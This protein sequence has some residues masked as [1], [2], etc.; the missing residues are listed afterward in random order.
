LTL[1]LRGV[2]AATPRPHSFARR[3]QAAAPID[4]PA[5]AY[6][7]KISRGSSNLEVGLF[8]AEFD[9]LVRPVAKRWL[10]VKNRQHPAMS[11]VMDFCAA[12]MS[13][14]ARPSREP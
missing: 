6:V 13:L 12:T 11:R 7:A 8:L 5:F 9:L 2:F 14:R 3:L 10:K 4:R 1:F